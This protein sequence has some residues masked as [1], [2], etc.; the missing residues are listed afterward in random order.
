YLPPA[1]LLPRDAL[2]LATLSAGFFPANYRVDAVPVPREQLD[3]ALEGAALLSRFDLETDDD[4]EILVPVPQQWFE[5]RLLKQETIDGEFDDTIARFRHTR[6]EWLYRRQSVRGKS[7]ALIE[8]ITAHRPAV[9]PLAED[10]EALEPEPHPENLQSPPPFRAAHL[11][12]IRSG[13]HQHFFQDA[14]Q[15]MPASQA[16]FAYV[17]VDR[18]NPPTQIMLQWNDGTGWPHRAYWGASRIEWG[19]EGTVS[20]LQISAEI[21]EPGRWVRLQVPTADVGLGGSAITGM[22]FTLFDG[23]V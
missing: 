22:A 14:S 10:P 9:P 17:Y 2:D 23:R 5:P 6:D 12:A 3:A 16:L 4:A 11:S 18:E 21:P 7:T 20:R 13:I 15:S 8:A 19:D 1:G